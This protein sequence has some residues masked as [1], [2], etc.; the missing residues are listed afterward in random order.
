LIAIDLGSNTV[1]AVKYD[2]ASGKKTATYEKIVKAADKVGSSGIINDEAKTR[3][4][5]AIE[6]MRQKLGADQ[7]TV[8][9]ATAVYR[10]AKNAQEV[11]KELE[12]RFG[13]KTRVIDGETEALLTS[14]AIEESLNT[15]GMGAESFMLV[16]IGGGS[17][18]I[19]FKK[20]D[21]ITLESF[22]IGIVSM[23]QKYKTKEMLE[24]GVKKECG[25]M[26]EFIKDTMYAFLKPQIFCATAGTP[27]TIAAIKAGMTYESYDGEKINGSLI[28]MDDVEK[29]FTKLL[30]ISIDER[31]KLVGALREDLI[32]AGILIFKEVFEAS[33]FQ[34]CRVFD[35]GLREGI[36]LA[37]CKKINIF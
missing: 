20:G 28:S 16:D 15:M 14:M 1:R 2:C 7:T 11:L 24:H 6:E 35:D 19:L 17:T 36:A 10:K 3:I 9:A 13:V 37:V 31:S 4:F 32:M 26:K 8:A 12:D 18:E 22:D 34:E 25:E 5:A 33:G 21:K 23:A 30:K 29:T 27:T